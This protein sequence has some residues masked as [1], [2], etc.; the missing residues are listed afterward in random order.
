MKKFLCMMGIC[1]CLSGCGRAETFETVADDAVQTMLAEPL[2]ISITL[3]EEAVLPVMETDTGRLYICRDFEVSVQTLSG[4]DLAGTIKTLTGY[5]P[6]DLSMV[7]TKQAEYDCYEFVWAAAAEL[8]D[9]V[10]RGLV[11]DDGNYHYCVCAMIDAE[12]VSAYG[13]IWNGMFETVRLG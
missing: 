3:P 1:L 2:E 11:L 6:E 10:G 12:E 4:G 9:Q 5:L 7:Q 8:G 13:E